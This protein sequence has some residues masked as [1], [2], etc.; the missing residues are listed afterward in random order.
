MKELY[1]L[2]QDCENALIDYAFHDNHKTWIAEQT[3]LFNLVVKTKQDQ[4]YINGQPKDVN[5]INLFFET[6]FNNK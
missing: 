2:N 4:A 3:I 6:Y 1:I 5:F